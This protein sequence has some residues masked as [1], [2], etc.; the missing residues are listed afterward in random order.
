MTRT[1][2]KKILTISLATIFGIAMI[3]SP[4]GV[5]AMGSFLDVKKAKNCYR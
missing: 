1:N 4:I 2:T 3:T 5:D